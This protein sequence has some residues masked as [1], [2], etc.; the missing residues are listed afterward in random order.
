[1]PTAPPASSST[2]AAV[3][4]PTLPRLL[5]RAW[6]LSDPATRCDMRCDA[7]DRATIHQRLVT[8][9]GD[10]WICAEC[11]QLQ[12]D[13]GGAPALTDPGQYDAKWM[14]LAA[15][16]APTE[17]QIAECRQ[18]VKRIEPY[19]RL[20]RLFE[21][22]CGLGLLL[23]TATDAGWA[24][25]GNDLSVVAAAHAT[26]LTGRPV[27][28]GPIEQ[29]TLEK[30]IYDV[31]LLNNVFEHLDEPRRVLCNL[32]AALRPGGVM[33]FQTLNGQSLSLHFAPTHWLYY[34]PGHLIV[35]TLVSLRAYF[36]AAGL[37]PV[38][39]ETHGFRTMKHADLHTT[40]KQKRLIDRLLSPLATGMRRGHRVK[41]L[42]QRPE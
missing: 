7:Q 38:R 34:G 28:S 32:A 2:S 24:A 29:V 3:Q 6:I 4:P 42:L 15:T 30:G 26:K 37:V 27:A 39:F 25:E 13:S 17:S 19:R 20:G 1:M 22:G 40:G 9:L 23:K 11:G 41:V 18:W 8:I 10:Y 12:R 14:R 31:I 16:F 35:P 36:K 21:V 33:F 5:R